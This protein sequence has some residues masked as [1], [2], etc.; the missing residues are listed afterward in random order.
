LIA[1]VVAMIQ[2]ANLQYAWTQFVQPLRD[3]QGWELS[4][5]QWGFSIFIALETWAMPL[6]GWLIDL[7]GARLLMSIAGVL[8]GIGWAGLGYVESLPALYFFYGLAGFGA[9]IV[10]CGSIGVALKWFPDRRGFAAG[11]IAAGFGAGSALYAEPV[12][13]ILR[14]QD[15]QAAFLYTGILQGILIIAAAQFLGGTGRAAASVASAKKSSNLRKRSD[16][17]NS[18]EMLKTYQFYWLYAMMLMMGIGGLLATAQVS[19]VANTFGIATG[20]LAVS[21]T[22]NPVANG[23]GRIFWGWV[24]DRIGREGTMQISFFIQALALIAVATIGA[25]NSVIFVIA[26]AMVF[27]TWGP[28]YVLF[29]STSADFFGSKNASSNYSFLYST[30]GVAA[31]IAGG[32]AAAVFEAT[33]SWGPAFLGSAMLAAL[34]CVMAIR[35]KKIPLPAKSGVPVAAMTTEP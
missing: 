27:F 5:V 18:G 34:A 24:S 30:K 33:G 32:S 23:T 21:L 13:Y 28:I 17:L 19:Q 25:Q 11:I 6:T 22:L 8:C 9:A 3:A 12:R 1:A 31:L 4:E 29:P 14:V 26:M 15:Y 2:I 7:K 10:Y 16:D 20:A 35:L